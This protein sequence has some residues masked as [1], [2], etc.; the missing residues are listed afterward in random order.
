[1]GFHKRFV[2]LTRLEMVR[3]SDIRKSLGIQPLHLQIEKS[4]LQWLGH[5]LRMPAE[6]KDKQLFL[7]NPT[8]RRPRGRRRL[9]WCKHVVGVC[10]R[11][12]LSFAEAHTLAQDRERWKYCLTRLPP[13]PERR[14][15]D[16]R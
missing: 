4:Q 2:G 10:S 5:V 16:G 7:A 3:N 13:R 9:S 11:L 6:R 1:M 8:G 12:D 15:G 14:S